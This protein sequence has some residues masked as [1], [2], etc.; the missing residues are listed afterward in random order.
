[1]DQ[2][3]YKAIRKKMVNNIKIIYGNTSINNELNRITKS[4]PYLVDA[5]KI[6]ENNPLSKYKSY[7]INDNKITETKNNS[8]FNYIINI[9]VI[10]LSKTGKE[11]EKNKKISHFFDKILTHKNEDI[12]DKICKQ[13]KYNPKIWRDFFILRF[14]G[15]RIEQAYNC[16]DNIIY[17]NYLP[18]PVIID[19][20]ILI[21]IN[22][23]TT[24]DD[25]KSIWKDVKEMQN[26]FE[27]NN[28]FKNEKREFI[29]FHRGKKTAKSFGEN[30]K[31][32][33]FSEKRK[34]TGYKKNGS[35]DHDEEVTYIYKIK[36]NF[37]KKYIDR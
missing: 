7:S 32:I 35:F 28:S 19:D 30:I 14:L 26:I 25:V 16:I 6:L 21:E 31:Y 8:L 20:K 18:K 5:S 13:N 29:T 37:K 2:K 10:Y 24:Q 34:K 15:L 3:T 9:I 36:K 12:F 27:K 23:L 1:M 22:E 33:N 17:H 4:N 11:K